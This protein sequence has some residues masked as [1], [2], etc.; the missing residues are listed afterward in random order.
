MSKVYHFVYITKHK[1]T[2]YFYVGKHKTKNL[3]DGYL[4]SGNNIKDMLKRYHKR[5]FERG[6]L[7]FAT[8]ERQCF[9][10]EGVYLNTYIDNPKCLNMSS[11]Y[12]HKKMLND[13]KLEKQC[14]SF[15]YTKSNKI[16]SHNKN[17]DEIK[18]L[19]LKINSLKNDNSN[20][21]DTALSI[22]QQL[23][24]SKQ[25]NSFLKERI[26][27]LNE[28]IDYLIEHECNREYKR[29]ALG[30]PLSALLYHD[31]RLKNKNK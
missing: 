21:Y 28:K 15:T 3:N 10:L 18:D 23:E 16:I 14:L 30:R 1:P 26:T 6:I 8:C 25:D 5:E 9:Y 22:N 11:G 29:P 31:E 4:G 19:W 2:G 7:A 20:L 27:F 17:N 13:K 24:L 12:T